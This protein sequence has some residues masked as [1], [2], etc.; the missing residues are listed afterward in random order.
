MQYPTTGD[1]KAAIEAVPSGT[2]LVTTYRDLRVTA[3][4][5]GV[6][7]VFTLFETRFVN[8]SGPGFTFCGAIT[9]VL[10]HRERGWQI[11]SGHSSTP[12]AQAR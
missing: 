8:S 3:L 11:V 4:A 6:A 12:S 10:A 5:P 1:I 9:M 2:R 7:S